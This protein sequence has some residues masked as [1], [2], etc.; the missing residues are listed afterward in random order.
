MQIEVK[1][2]AYCCYLVRW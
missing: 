2:F 1:T